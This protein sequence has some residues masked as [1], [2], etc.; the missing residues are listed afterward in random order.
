MSSFSA[1]ARSAFSLSSRAPDSIL[2]MLA[3]ETP[4]AAIW[5]CE[6][7]CCS[8]RCSTCSPTPT[9]LGSP[10]SRSH[11]CLRGVPKGGSR[12][13]SLPPQTVRCR[14][15]PK[16]GEQKRSRLKVHLRP[17]GAAP[18]GAA[19]RTPN[20]AGCHMRHLRTRA[21]EP[22][23]VLSGSVAFCGN[24]DRATLHL[25]PGVRRD[26]VRRRGVRG[27]SRARRV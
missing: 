11:P 2:L 23:T 13:A 3:F 7:P 12:R 6:R 10:S 26:R 1:S 9:H 15:G 21:L 24:Y 19:P 27:D 8:R 18:A 25:T 20:H 14:T 5:R 4:G 17:A 16:N 22:L